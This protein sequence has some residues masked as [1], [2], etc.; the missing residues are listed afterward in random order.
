MRENQPLF[1]GSG[2]DELIMLLRRASAKD[3]TEFPTIRPE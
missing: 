3:P 2:V 1:R